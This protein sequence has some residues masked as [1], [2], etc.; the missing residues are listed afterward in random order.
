MSRNPYLPLDL[1]RN[2]ET[3]LVDLLATTAYKIFSRRTTTN[4]GGY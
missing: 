4:H 2:T 3:F 1:S